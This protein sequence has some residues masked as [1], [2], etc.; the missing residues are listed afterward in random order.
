MM[1]AFSMLEGRAGR[2]RDG[3]LHMLPGGGRA[4]G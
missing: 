2:L 4:P 1:G 3:V